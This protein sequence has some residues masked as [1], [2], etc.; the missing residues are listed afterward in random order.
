MNA[1][2]IYLT[3]TPGWG[4][5]AGAEVQIANA[6]GVTKALWGCRSVV[7]VI[8]ISKDSWGARGTGIRNI[9]M[10][11]SSL[12]QDYD[13]IKGSVAVVMNRYTP[14]EMAEMKNQFA[15]ML[16]KM[17]QSDKANLNYLAFIEHLHELAVRNSL[18]KFDPIVDN[19]KQL[20][21]RLISMPF[22][23]PSQLF[24]VAKPSS[25]A[26]NAYCKEVSRRVE[27]H[28]TKNNPEMV[29]YYTGNLESLRD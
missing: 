8:V 29:K 12:F 7:P 13:R 1:G 10:I 17:E 2:D 9:G 23:K 21:D 22:L 6:F 4:D 5:T 25:V 11:V 27:Y 18:L 20:L 14:E 16:D 19:P 15:D 3:D 28:L 24:Q 26:I